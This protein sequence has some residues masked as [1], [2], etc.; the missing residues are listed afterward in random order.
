MIAPSQFRGRPVELLT[1]SACETASGDENSAR[2]ALGLAGVAVRAGARSALATLW[3]ADDAATTR[4][5][6]AFYRF[7]S[8]AAAPSKAQALREA[9]LQLLSTL[10]Y[11]HPRFWAPFVI[12]GNW[13]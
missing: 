5:M 1:L 6:P 2:A 10:R 13:R 7:L 3:L 9:Q 12:I 8:S 4:L 11:Q